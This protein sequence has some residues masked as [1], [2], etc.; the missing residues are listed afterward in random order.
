M[1]SS[2]SRPFSQSALPERGDDGSLFLTATPEWAQGRTLFGG[3]VA[4]NLYQAMASLAQPDQLLRSI[5]VSFPAPISLGRARLDAD[6]DRAGGSTSF[7][8]A[9]VI[10]DGDIRTRCHAV[11]ARSRPSKIVVSAP[12]PQLDLALADAPEFP[13]IE[14]V[15]PEFIQ[16]FDIRWGIGDWPFSGSD[17]G[18]LG[19]YIRHRDSVSG[20]AAILGLL[21]AWPPA[22]LPMAQGR[23]AS[24]TISW[25]T[26]IVDDIPPASDAWYEFRSDTVSSRDGYATFTGTLSQQGRVIAWS[27]QLAAVFD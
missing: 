9:T 18:T 7:T 19:G 10:Q 5:S 6:L 24:S 11:F 1:A 4:A 17:R 8:S 3:L 16:K 15:M 13:Y 21:D 25:T 2:Q 26:H 12:L 20:P 14:G 27:E 22:V 23:A